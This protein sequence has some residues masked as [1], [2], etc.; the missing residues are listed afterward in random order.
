[1]DRPRSECPISFSLEVVG[2][3]WS[4]LVIRDLVF[5]GKNTYN[6]FVASKE[7]MARNILAER[8]NRLQQMGILMAAPHPV[9]GRKKVYQLTERGLELIPVLTD[10]VE[11]GAHNAPIT[12][13]N[14]GSMLYAV[15]ARA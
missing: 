11:W 10:L 3:P 14:G 6:D 13:R 1:M 12:N 8:L 5:F 15:T 7:G 9:D 2:D 4:L